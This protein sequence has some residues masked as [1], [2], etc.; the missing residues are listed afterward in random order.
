[1]AY[2]N[3]PYAFE[4]QTPNFY[5]LQNANGQYVPKPPSTQGGVGSQMTTTGFSGVGA[6]APSS[7]AFAQAMEGEPQADVSKPNS[8]SFGISNAA[9]LAGVAL[10]SYATGQAAQSDP[11]QFAQTDLNGVSGAISG[12]SAGGW[13]GAIVGS[14]AE[15][16]AATDAINKKLKN[17]NTKVDAVSYG[18]DGQPMYNGQGL[19]QQLGL[20][21]DLDAAYT[22]TRDQWNPL[23]IHNDFFN[24]TR[25]KIRKAR[26]KVD[27]SITKAQTDFNVQR[28][29]YD[30]NQAAM[31]GFRRR[32]D[33]TN[34]LYNL[35][36]T[37]QTFSA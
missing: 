35:Y 6:S 9:S 8:S 15:Q 27:R 10:S 26:G 25:G 33:S 28:A 34:R 2:F 12:A 18:P 31:Q 7:G 20:L 30:Q 19:T 1:M 16:V 11:S 17:V 24:D 32:R 3:N 37:P 14:V 23:N 36:N 5:K 13:I 4:S 29:S 22:K 21:S